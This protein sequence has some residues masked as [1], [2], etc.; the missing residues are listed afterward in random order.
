MGASFAHKSADGRILFGQWASEP[1][2]FDVTDHPF[3]EYCRVLEGTLR[4]TDSDGSVHLLEP[5]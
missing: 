5:G 1:A 2:V 3:L 4:A